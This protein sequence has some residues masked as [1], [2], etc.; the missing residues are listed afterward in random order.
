MQDSE[1]G[2][3]GFLLTMEPSFLKP[4]RDSIDEI[5]RREDALETAI[6][7]S[8]FT[9]IDV[10][11]LRT[12]DRAENHRTEDDAVSR[13]NQIVAIRLLELVKNQVGLTLNERYP[14]HSRRG[15]PPRPTGRLPVNLQSHL[16][17][18]TGLRIVTIAGAIA[19]L[20]VF[21]NVFLIIRRYVDEI[22]AARRELEGLNAGWSSASANARETLIQANPEI[23]RFAYIV[24]H[25]LRAPLVNIMGFTSE[26]DNA[27]E[28]HQSYFKSEDGASNKAARSEIN[29]RVSG[30]SA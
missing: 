13:S 8:R 1:S 11:P 17:L 9:E 19:V 21:V 29:A 30:R 3:R 25:D 14:R 6:A 12:S 4:Y 5:S 18:A 27:I 7:G 24:T 26:L 16:G 2:Q 15:H 23:Q 22:L 20:A 28:D 10:E